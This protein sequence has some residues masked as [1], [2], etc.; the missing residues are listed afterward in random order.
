M[1]IT[2]FFRFFYFHA[3]GESLYTILNANLVL[4]VLCRQKRG[5]A[6]GGHTQTRGPVRGRVG[7]HAA[8]AAAAMAVAAETTA[9]TTM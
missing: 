4:Q 5:Q 2:I 7:I 9:P 1:S 8:A 3:T 6:Q